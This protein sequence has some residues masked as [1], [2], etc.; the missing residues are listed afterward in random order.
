MLQNFRG[1]SIIHAIL[2]IPI[3][4]VG[5][6]LPL[7]FL[8]Q[9]DAYLMYLR[10]EELLVV[11]AWGWVTYALIGLLSGMAFVVSSIIAAKVMRRPSA[12]WTG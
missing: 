12:S 7:D 6:V 11:F 3:V 9:I 8:A 1:C 5:V 4:C 2:V 10:M